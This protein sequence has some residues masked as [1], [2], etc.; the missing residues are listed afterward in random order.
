MIAAIATEPDLAE[1]LFLVAFII[2]VV[3]TVIHVMAKA[4]PAALTAAGFACLAL[5]F[6]LL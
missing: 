1:V 4:M 6:L 3:V 2:F 5:A